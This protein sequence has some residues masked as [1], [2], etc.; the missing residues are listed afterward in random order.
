[1]R[2]S[3]SRVRLGNACSSTL[4]ITH[5]PAQLTPHPST[6]SPTLPH[7]RTPT[8]LLIPTPTPLPLAFLRQLARTSHAAPPPQRAVI[9][10][11]VRD[12]Q[13]AVLVVAVRLALGDG[14]AVEPV[15]G[16][17]EDCVHFFE[18]A[19]ARLREE[20]VGEWE[21]EGV[22]VGGRGGGDVSSLW[23]GEG[24]LRSVKRGER[25]G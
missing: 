12:D 16:L 10:L 15:C 23:F 11:I 22:A 20:E 13:M 2:L 9:R 5:N 19:Q 21:D 18:G 8:I 3:R 6:S 24:L 4:L 14:D 1:M 17:E 7:L 25:E